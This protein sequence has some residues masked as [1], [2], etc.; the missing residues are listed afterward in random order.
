MRGTAVRNRTVQ[1]E[2]LLLMLWFMVVEPRLE[3]GVSVDM[4]A[5]RAPEL[6]LFYL[7]SVA[8]ALGGY[9]CRPWTPGAGLGGT[10]FVQGYARVVVLGPMIAITALGLD[11]VGADLA[12]TGL[13]LCPAL[14]L[15]VL[16]A[17]RERL[18][19][20]HWF[21]RRLSMLPLMI[22]GSH[23]FT[24][25]AEDLQGGLAPGELVDLLQDPSLRLFGVLILFGLIVEYLGFVYAPRASADA[26][27]T[28]WQWLIRFSLFVGAV[29]FGTGGGGS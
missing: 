4:L 26:G 5:R 16:F 9:F 25:M 24:R 21:V 7:V 3:S 15:G 1:F 10:T 11:L 6:G 27:G 29:L 22:I 12:E 14:G 23:W 20:L 2:D 18:P 28:W 17:V 13:I 19:V 8:L